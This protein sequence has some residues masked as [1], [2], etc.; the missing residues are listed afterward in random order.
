MHREKERSNTHEKGKKEKQHAQRKIAHTITIHT[1]V[2][3]DSTHNNNNTKRDST[4]V[5]RQCAQQ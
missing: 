1:R 4:H 3:K 2:K 5:E